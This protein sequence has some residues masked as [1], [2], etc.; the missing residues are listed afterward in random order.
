[1]HKFTDTLTL[2]TVPLSKATLTRAGF[3]PI[4][5][6]ITTDTT[7]S[8]T[9]LTIPDDAVTCDGVWTLQLQPSDGCCGRCLQVNLR[10]CPPVVNP[11]GT[12]TATPAYTPV[13]TCAAEDTTEG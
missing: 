12:Y 9:T 10:N 1:M 11:T 2:S 4:E 3:L 7:N 5:L 13:E 8:L 6:T